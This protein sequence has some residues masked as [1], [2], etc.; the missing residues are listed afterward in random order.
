MKY[1]YFLLLGLILSFSSFAFEAGRY[2]GQNTDAS[3]I[4]DL[5]QNEQT[6]LV[7]YDC[8]L[9]SGTII[10]S[11]LFQ[12]YPIG[13]VV[14]EVE[15][16]TGRYRVSLLGSD[17]LLEYKIERLTGEPMNWIERIT[18][19]SDGAIHYLMQLDQQVWLDIDL[20]LEQN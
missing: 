19:N 17:S 1:F 13:S 14:Q 11:A 7:K 18:K 6:V 2:I 4:L 5:D 9:A 16:E 15:D 3:C 10:Q 12:P 20:S 8:K